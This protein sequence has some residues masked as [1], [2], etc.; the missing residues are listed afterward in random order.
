MRKTLVVVVGLVTFTLAPACSSE[1]DPFEDCDVPGGTRDVCSAGTVCG[2]PTDK[3]GGFAC[4]PICVDD[5]DC[6]KD[7]DCKGVDGTSLKGCRLKL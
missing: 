1:S 3:S 5:K 7:Y 2:K 6:P 4:I